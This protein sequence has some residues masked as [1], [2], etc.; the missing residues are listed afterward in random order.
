MKR[1]LSSDG[2]C[3]KREPVGTLDWLRASSRGGSVVRSEGERR[4]EWG[5]FQ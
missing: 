5:T 2:I 3:G 4:K 1:Y